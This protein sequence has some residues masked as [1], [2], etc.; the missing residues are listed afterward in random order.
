MRA[1]QLCLM[2]C[3]T[4]GLVACGNKPT[5]SPGPNASANPTGATNGPPASG[6]PKDMIIGKWQPAKDSDRAR[7][8]DWKAVATDSSNGLIIKFGKDGECLHFAANAGPQ[9]FAPALSYQFLDDDTI[10]LTMRMIGAT[11]GKVDDKVAPKENSLK[12]KVKVTGDELT[13]TDEKGNSEKYTRKPPVSANITIKEL[14]LHC[15]KCVAELKKS[16]DQA[17]VSDLAID[18]AKKTATLKIKD[19]ENWHQVRDAV[20]RAGMHGTL[21]VNGK[22]MMEFQPVA[23]SIGGQPKPTTEIV[24]PGV[25]VCC[26]GCQKAITDIAKDAKVSFEGEGP[27]KTVKITGEKLDSNMILLGLW[28]AGFRTIPSG[29]TISPNGIGPI[30]KGQ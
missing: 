23:F 30:I 21:E 28:K 18:L 17:G 29:P 10:Q 20:D 6:K 11:I 19:D 9:A 14:P 2:G 27:L 15:D 26:P 13:L 22:P 8:I 5:G 12:L 7:R 24:L 3:L 16:L 4:L 25:H 1:V